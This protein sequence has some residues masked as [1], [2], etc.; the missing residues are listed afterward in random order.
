VDLTASY[1]TNWAKDYL[2]RNGCR[3]NRVNNIPVRRRKGT[4]EK[5]WSDLQGYTAQGIYLAVEV[6][7][8]GDTL[9]AEQI[10]RLEDIIMCNGLAFICTEINN[11][12]ALI[13]F[14]KFEYKK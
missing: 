13:D 3:L 5:G 9:K 7:K 14:K 8:K 2:Q 4:I 12:P 10:N 6:K 1:L 11:K